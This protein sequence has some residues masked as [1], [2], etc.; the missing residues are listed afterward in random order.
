M[1][2]KLCDL[3]PLPTELLKENARMIVPHM[4]S[5]YSQWI[6]SVKIFSNTSE[7]GNVPT[8]KPRLDKNELKTY[9]P[10]SDISILAKILEKIVAKL[11]NAHL[12][13]KK[14]QD[15]FSI[16]VPL[17]SLD[18]DSSLKCTVKHFMS[19][20]QRQLC[21]S[22]YER[23]ISSIGHHDHAVLIERLRESFCVDA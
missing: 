11:L 6:T 23:L 1:L 21:Y 15:V 7:E 12:Q 19:N 2:S 17:S 9:R 10:A 8:E 14:L 20:E 18:G 16:S 5:I 3:E 22:A 4:A 13:F